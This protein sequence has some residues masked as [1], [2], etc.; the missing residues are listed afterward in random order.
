MVLGDREFGSVDFAKWLR[1]QNLHFCLR[2]KCS[3]CIQTPSW[4]WR[5]LKEVGLVSGSS[6][7]FSGVQVRK[8][9]P[10]GGFNVACKWKRKYRGVAVKEGWFLL[11]SLGSVSEAVA[12]YR[13]RMGIEEMFRDDKR[14][15][16]NLEGTGLE[17][18][19]LMAKILLI[20]IASSS[21]IMQGTSFNKKAT[22][23]Y[24][25][26]PKEEGRKYARRSTFGSGVDSHSLAYIPG[27]ARGRGA[28]VNVIN[29]ESTPLLS[30]RD[31][32]CNPASVGFLAIFVTPS[33]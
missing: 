2:L 27:K 28:R 6:L 10:T 9:Q 26:L 12:A 5:A 31:E 8:S 1:A 15:G 11:T 14:G 22:K 33:V 17:G 18:K 13:K 32:G 3:L 24:I 20:A 16:Y 23:E 25:V 19:R 7:Y 21:A 29:S 4:G 30:A